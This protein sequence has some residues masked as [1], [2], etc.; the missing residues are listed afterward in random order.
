MKKL[1]TGFVAEYER[2]L[3]IRNQSKYSLDRF[4]Y[5]KNGIFVGL[6]GYVSFIIMGLILSQLES[7]SYVFYGINIIIFVSIY[8]FFNVRETYIKNHQKEEYNQLYFVVHN[9]LSVYDIIIMVYALYFI[10]FDQSFLQGVEG[11]MY[12]I[13]TALYFVVSY[14]LKKDLLNMFSGLSITLLLVGSLLLFEDLHVLLQ[15][16]IT[17]VI[18][19]IYYIVKPV[20]DSN[21][22]GQKLWIGVILCT[23]VIV[24]VSDLNKDDYNVYNRKYKEGLKIERI[25]GFEGI[26]SWN[27]AFNG[28]YVF[29]L[30]SESN[31]ILVFNLDF[32]IKETISI[33]VS[34]NEDIG[35]FDEKGIVYYFL[36]SPDETI[37]YMYNG[38]TNQFE[39]IEITIGEIKIKDEQY[40]NMDVY[41]YSNGYY[42]MEDNGIYVVVDE[43]YE[44]Y[45][46]IP[47]SID[48][49]YGGFI[50]LGD[51]FLI[52][53]STSD[54]ENFI[55]LDKNAAIISS[56]K[57][58]DYKYVRGIE[59]FFNGPSYHGY[60]SDNILFGF[61]NEGNYF[62][63]NS[64]GYKTGTTYQI[65]TIGRDN[66]SVLSSTATRDK[67]TMYLLLASLVFPLRL[68]EEGYDE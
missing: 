42:V 58:Q 8:M 28:D 32:S 9:C 65:T 15:F 59:T 16:T 17:V 61:E 46:Q 36:E 2:I 35:I 47:D 43:E 33:E 37:V 6:I 10:F 11:V 19:L 56:Y 53:N 30:D 68:R 39:E 14:V 44:F 41:L 18:V 27:S 21:L 57:K 31:E 40:N 51:Y 55:L 25:D 12:W 38:N 64:K 54:I 26:T 60:F 50:S 48:V 49:E 7:K 4:F 5:V 29:Q 24:F 1:L 52:S 3:A 62:F 67:V 22:K 34:D 63:V 13:F 45:A 66:F 23:I 20:I